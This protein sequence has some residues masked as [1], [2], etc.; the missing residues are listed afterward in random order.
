MSPD[1]ACRFD[2]EFAPHIA[3]TIAGLLGE[4]VSTEVVRHG[5]HGHPTQVN[6]VAPRAE[7]P[8]GYPH[9]LNIVLTWDT[10]EIEQL[11]AAGGTAR[12]EHYL[13]ALPRKLAAWE[14]ARGIDFGSRT[15]ADALVLLG[16]LDFAA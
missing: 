1:T 15:Q 12:F 3:R 8:R 9:P 4:P 7:H 11:M 10:D 14:S 2:T 16:G 5:G 6:I 13:A